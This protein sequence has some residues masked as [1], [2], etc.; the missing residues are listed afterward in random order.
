MSRAVRAVRAVPAVLGA[1]AAVGIIGLGGCGDGS[2]DSLT[3]F[4]ASSLTESF[5]EIAGAFEADTATTVTT[6]FDGSAR[7]ATQIE[8]GAPAD[9]F[10][11]ADRGTMD[12]AVATRGVRR[13]PEVFARNRLTIV[14]PAGNPAEIRGLDDLARSDV[15]LALADPSVP[16]GNYSSQALDR[17]GVTVRPATLE[18]SVRGVVT[19]VGL[20]EADAGIVYESDVVAGDGS[21]ESVTIPDALNV[22]AEYVI[23]VLEDAPASADGFMDFV[24]SDEGRRV[25]EE[26]GFLVP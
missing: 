5:E 4:A 24:M 10:A 20:G 9:V 25:L 18:G 1:V 26:K 6:D 2:S 14:V 22:S 11:A 16:A 17:A 8:H 15:V 13:A 3:V 12:A 23:A 21:V 19:K 7:L